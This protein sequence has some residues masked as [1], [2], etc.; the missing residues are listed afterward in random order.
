MD[1]HEMLRQIRAEL[2]VRPGDAQRMPDEALAQACWYADTYGYRVIICQACAGGVS[3]PRCDETYAITCTSCKGSAQ[4]V[5][6]LA[7]GV[8]LIVKCATCGGDGTKPCPCCEEFDTPN[9]DHCKDTLVELVPLQEA[10]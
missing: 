4:A 7:A 10:A 1:Q 6:Q 5:Y 8:E 9:C 3:C 2:I